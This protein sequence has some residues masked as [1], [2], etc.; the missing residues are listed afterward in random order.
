MWQAE[1]KFASD[2]AITEIVSL[3]K[4]NLISTNAS[5]QHTACADR[6]DPGANLEHH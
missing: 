6:A 2:L 3:S 1:N 4:S 5:K